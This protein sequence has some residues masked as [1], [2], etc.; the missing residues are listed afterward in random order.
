MSFKFNQYQ[1][2][3]SDTYISL[4]TLDNPIISYSE[5]RKKCTILYSNLLI[6]YPNT[7]YIQTSFKRINQNQNIQI[8]FKED[9]LQEEKILNQHIVPSIAANMTE[10]NF[11]D[12]LTIRSKNLIYSNL[13]I[14]ITL[15]EPLP[16]DTNI[17]MSLSLYTIENILQYI[18][19][20]SLIRVGIQGNPGTLFCINGEP[21]RISSS[22]IFELNNSRILINSLGVIPKEKGFFIIDYQYK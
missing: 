4:L 17:E 10:S 13:I 21:L 2:N 18:G 20:N 22:G 3:N 7:Y 19:V 9:L 11:E 16:E 5:D 8:S 1:K 6:N 12:I 14:T 15:E